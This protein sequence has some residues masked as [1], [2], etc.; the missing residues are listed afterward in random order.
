MSQDPTYPTP[1]GDVPDAAEVV[2]AFFA[3]SESREG[4]DDYLLGVP[5]EIRERVR[6]MV[7]DTLTVEMKR[8][9]LFKKH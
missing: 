1:E 9:N 7:L 5:E 8:L 4:L 3:R 6:C 2:A